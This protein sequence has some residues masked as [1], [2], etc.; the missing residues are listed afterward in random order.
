MLDRG[1]PVMV[2]SG[3]NDATDVNFLGVD[4]WLELL[5]GDRAAAFHAAPRTQWKDADGTVLGYLQEGGGLTN[6]AILG[7]GHLAA[8]DQPLLIDLIADRLLAGR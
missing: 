5:T 2:V 4:A 8:A 3:L 6:V 7:A 1:V